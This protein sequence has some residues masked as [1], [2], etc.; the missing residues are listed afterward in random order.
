MV[1]IIFDHGVNFKGKD[2]GLT[3]RKRKREWLKLNHQGG[4]TSTQLESLKFWFLIIT[5]L[6]IDITSPVYKRTHG[7]VGIVHLN[8][9]YV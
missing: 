3:L 6:N 4:G 9:C 8:E 5:N 7:V 1:R 2:L